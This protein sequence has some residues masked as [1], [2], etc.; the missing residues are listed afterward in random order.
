MNIE[1]GFS[2]RR[3]SANDDALRDLSLHKIA[4]NARDGGL[5]NVST[6]VPP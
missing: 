5:V 2:E 6:I 4:E 1:R 3:D